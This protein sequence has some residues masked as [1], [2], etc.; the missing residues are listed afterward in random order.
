LL[1]R[2][3]QWSSLLRSGRARQQQAAKKQGQSQIHPSHMIVFL[4]NRES[5][6]N[7]Q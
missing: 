3:G 2:R 1:L 7:R 4:L 5:Q 6:S